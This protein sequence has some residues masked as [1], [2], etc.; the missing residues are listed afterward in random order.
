MKIERRERDGG[1][2]LAGFGGDWGLEYDGMGLW[3]WLL[4]VGGV[5]FGM[6]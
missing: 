2:L 5:R 1:E 4:Q 6:G 3:A